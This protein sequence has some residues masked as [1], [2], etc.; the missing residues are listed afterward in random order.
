MN[1]QGI[2]WLQVSKL[3]MWKISSQISDADHVNI[4]SN[5]SDSGDDF[6]ATDNTDASTNCSVRT[7]KRRI[8]RRE[9]SHLSPW[10]DDEVVSIFVHAVCLVDDV[11]VALTMPF[12][13]VLLK[14]AAYVSSFRFVGSRF[15]YCTGRAHVCQSRN[16]VIND[17]LVFVVQS[18]RQESDETNPNPVLKFADDCA[19]GNGAFL[20]PRTNGM[21][22][23]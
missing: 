23:R 19:R 21:E 18:G 12:V 9:M 7:D 22:V 17:F 13:D 2:F 10:I 5:D 8:P 3:L 11:S 4:E 14:A 20:Y 15:S 1:L 16:C 6:F